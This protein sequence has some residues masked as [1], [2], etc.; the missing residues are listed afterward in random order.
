M[1]TPKEFVDLKLVR[2]SLERET[3]D[4]QLA[5]SR[6]HQ[7]QTY[8]SSINHFNALSHALADMGYKIAYEADYSFKGKL[9][10]W[11]RG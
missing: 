11:S 5:N 6:T 2:T 4:V 3:F 9:R 1:E 7:N 10:R 8:A